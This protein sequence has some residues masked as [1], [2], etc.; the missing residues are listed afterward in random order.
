MNPSFR[1]SLGLIQNV[2]FP[3]KN[4]FPL[5]SG[6]TAS[7]CPK[8]VVSFTETERLVGDGETNM[9]QNY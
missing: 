8:L 4:A 9:C 6:M 3:V 1:E 5:T 7:Y 2:F